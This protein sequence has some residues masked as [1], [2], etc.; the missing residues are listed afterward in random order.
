[1]LWFLYIHIE[2]HLICFMWKPFN[3]HITVNENIISIYYKT[4]LHVAIY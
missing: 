3:S 1:M 4:L 2:Y